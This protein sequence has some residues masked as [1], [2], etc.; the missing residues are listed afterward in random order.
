ML[1]EKLKPREEHAV[2]QLSRL[3]LEAWSLVSRDR[4]LDPSLGDLEKKDPCMAAGTLPLNL[5]LPLGQ[6]SFEPMWEHWGSSHSQNIHAGRC[7]YCI[8]TLR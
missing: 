1:V 7:V 2:T 5:Q 6:G 3:P 8:Y 4:A